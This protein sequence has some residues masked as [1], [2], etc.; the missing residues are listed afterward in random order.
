M[1]AGHVHAKDSTTEVR[2]YHLSQ[3]V[4]EHFRAVQT[5]LISSVI[6]DR[7]RNDVWWGKY[8]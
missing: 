1:K 2:N 5:H 6:N 8:F 7:R 4:K 3:N